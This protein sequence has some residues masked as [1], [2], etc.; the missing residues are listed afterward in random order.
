M[1]MLTSVESNVA[2][3]VYDNTK[4][5]KKSNV[6]GKTIGNP[7]LSEKAAKYYEQLK[8]KYSNMDFILVSNDKKEQAKAQAA[9]YANP[10]K[11]VVL[12][13]EEKIEKMATD[14]NYRKQYES[15]I[16]NA[17]TQLPQ[18]QN[19]LG[20]T[21]ANVKAYGIQI[22]DN[23]TASYF[24]VIDN[25]LASQKERIEKKAQEKKE[26]RKN[27]EKKEAKEALAEELEE[28][29][30]KRKN[31]TDK[32]DKV[33]ITASSVEELISKINDMTFIWMSDN[34]QTDAEKMVGQHFDMGV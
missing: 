24:A 31:E 2:T 22:N 28:K 8:Q 11:M 32:S 10:D 18:M 13:D 16:S 17:A 34:V 25:S 19:G 27:Q 1:S 21:S 23:G 29:R 12:I 5:E 9:S 30:S 26:I 7:K 4:T 15:I 33:T 14:E 20:T 6:S 3:S